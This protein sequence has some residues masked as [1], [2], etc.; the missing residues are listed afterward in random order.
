MNFVRIAAL[1]A[2][3]LLSGCLLTPGK[4][5]AELT[6][7]KDGSFTYHYAGEIVLMTAQGLGE[8]G[9]GAAAA[10]DKFDPEMQDCVDQQTPDSSEP[11]ARECTPAELET[12]RKEWEAN[13]ATRAA[14]KKAEDER[15]RAMFGGMDV[16]DPKTMDEF[17]RRLQGYEGW[18]RVVHKGKGVFDPTIDFIIPFVEVNRAVG[19]KVRINAP[20]FVQGSDSG[21]KAL[22]GN[23]GSMPTGAGDSAPRP[24]GTFTVTTDAEVLTNNTQD[25]PAPGAGGTRVL[26][27]VVGPL[28]AK[29]PEALLQLR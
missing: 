20:A 8:M 13:K 6:L 23:A 22:A 18:K 15:T 14:E 12:K 21:L 25:G 29:K 4:F 24:Q 11:T 3:M 7:K 1:G 17:A 27:W 19:N 9:A 2:L 10:E 16:N 26:T 5:N 28:D